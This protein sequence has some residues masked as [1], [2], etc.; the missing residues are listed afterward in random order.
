MKKSLLSLTLFLAA[1]TAQAQTTATATLNIKLNA[2]QSIQIHPGQNTTLLEYSTVADYNEGVSI[3]RKN[4]V[5]VFSNS[6][7]QVAVSGGDLTGTSA[8][9]I[10]ANTVRVTPSDGNVQ[11]ATPTYTA[12]YLSQTP[13]TII[14]STTGGN[15]ERFDIQYKGGTEYFLKARET[16]STLVTYTVTPL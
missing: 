11:H 13:Q 14:S 10:E 15:K 16:Y 9:T 4:H 12:A 1:I 2:V 8:A 7:F 6:G 5:E 3:T